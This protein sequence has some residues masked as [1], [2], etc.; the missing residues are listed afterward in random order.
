MLRIEGLTLHL[1]TSPLSSYVLKNA[2][3]NDVVA[4]ADL[5]V[6][7]VRSTTWGG[8]GFTDF[9]SLCEG[10]FANAEIAVLSMRGTI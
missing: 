3:L 2:D 1:S 8:S 7:S 10:F 6:L 4:N 5:A 9:T